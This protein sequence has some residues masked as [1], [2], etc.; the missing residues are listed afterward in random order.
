M[1]K[2]KG[3]TLRQ[4]GDLV[5]TTAQ[6]VQR[7]E[8]AN[9]TVSTDW[10]DRFARAFSVQAVDLIRDKRL[11]GI[12]IYG[13]LGPDGILNNAKTD[14]S[15]L[16]RLSLTSP[17]QDPVAVRLSRAIG[18]YRAGA[19]LIGNRL[20]NENHDENQ[21]RDALVMTPDNQLVL[22]RAIWRESNLTL[23]SL[24]DGGTIWF[25]MDAEWVAP[26]VMEIRYL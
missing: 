10:L 9:M 26:L 6:T 17:A 5:G 23:V 20:A 15:D 4:V 13:H 8:T 1:R 2:A 24:S 19:T 21:G 25:D 11:A 12:P 7:L 18:P 16:E 3:W 22:G 14:S